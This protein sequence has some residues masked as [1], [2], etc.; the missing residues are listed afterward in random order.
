MVGGPI[1]SGLRY[2]IFDINSSILLLLVHKYT[3]FIAILLETIMEDLVNRENIYDTG[4]S[5]IQYFCQYLILL[6]FDFGH[7]IRSGN[8]QLS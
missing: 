1:F 6:T 2:D 5:I 4:F 3:V 7:D 8:F